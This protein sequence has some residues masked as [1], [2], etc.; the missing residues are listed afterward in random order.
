MNGRDR[1]P[2]RRAT[3]TDVA[4]EAGVAT[5]TV[6][7]AFSDPGR[8]NAHTREHVLAVAARLGYSPN[9][10]A[11]AVKAGR[12]NTVAMV[13]PDITN[14]YFAGV[15]KGAEREAARPD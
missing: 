4:R 13:V 14:P 11:R 1:G 6:S 8:V 10:A 7:R 9:P 2:R 12:S 5:S 3:I 15:I